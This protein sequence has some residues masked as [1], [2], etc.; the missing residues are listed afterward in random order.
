MLGGKSTISAEDDV[1]DVL[2][3][4]EVLSPRLVTSFIILLALLLS[5][6]G[7][8]WCIEGFSDGDALEERMLRLRVYQALFMHDLLIV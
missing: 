6:L 4:L 2:R 1:D 8:G 5:C 3:I 7:E